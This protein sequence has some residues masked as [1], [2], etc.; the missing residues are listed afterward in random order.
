MLSDST[1]E[2]HGALSLGVAEIRNG[3]RVFETF[4][5]PNCDYHNAFTSQRLDNLS[6]GLD[7]TVSRADSSSVGFV[8]FG[9]TV[10][11]P[12]VLL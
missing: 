2:W 6:A 12:H 5:E 9:L 10:L 3:G 1:R 8:G 11:N 4:V 7:N